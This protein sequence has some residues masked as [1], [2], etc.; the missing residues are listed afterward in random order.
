M[1][2]YKFAFLGDSAVGKTS[3]ISRFKTDTF[4]PYYI[5]TIFVDSDETG[6][7]KKFKIEDKIYKYITIEYSGNTKWYNGE[8]IPNF[9]TYVD[10]IFIIYDVSSRESFE[11]IDF[12]INE[13]GKSHNFYGLFLVANKC[14]KEREIS[15][16]EGIMKSKSIGY[17][18]IETSAKTRYKIDEL[19]INMTNEVNRN[20]PINIVKKLPATLA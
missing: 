11:N 14:D 4:Y 6:Y 15:E 2:A 1:N 8:P 7:Q 10:G 19:F 5:P 3:I 18:Y 13:I 20:K 9:F 12:W 16:E 17:R